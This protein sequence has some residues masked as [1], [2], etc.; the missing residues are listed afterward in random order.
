MAGT[1]RIDFLSNAAAGNGVS[2]SYKGGKIALYAEATWGGGNVKLQF[3]SPQG[4]WIDVPSSTLSANGFVILEVPPGQYR[5]VVTTAS[6]AYASAV[7]VPTN[8]RH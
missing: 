4:T 8:T 1:E 5:A 2:K 3:Q 6:A 7:E